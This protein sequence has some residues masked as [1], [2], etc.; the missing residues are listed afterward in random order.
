VESTLPG[1]QGNAV[2]YIPSITLRWGLELT[3]DAFNFG[4]N[5]SYVGRQYSD[6]TN[7]VRSANPIVGEI[8]A[9][10]I[11]DLSFGYKIDSN[12]NIEFHVNNLFDTRY[13]T[14]RAESYPG[15]GIIPAEPRIMTLGCI[16]NI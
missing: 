6:A 16:W 2:E 11:A 12:I 8:P 3:I 7:A 4:L 10:T 1:I 5:M 9:Y 13:F 15:P 14:R